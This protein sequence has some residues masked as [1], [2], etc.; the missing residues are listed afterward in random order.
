MTILALG[1]L[2][3]PLLLKAG[4]PE[5]KSIGLITSASSLGVL[6]APSVPLIMY[7]IMARVPINTMFVAGL[8]PALVM[9]FSL[10]IFGRFITFPQRVGRFENVVEDEL[11][12][13]IL[14]SLMDILLKDYT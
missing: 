11:G 5:S 1:G 10:L 3:L 9:V 7:A 4:Y 14:K 6:L 13:K 12:Q 8:I 2:M